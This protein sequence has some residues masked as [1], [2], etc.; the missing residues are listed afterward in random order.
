MF[1]LAYHKWVPHQRQLGPL[2]LLWDLDHLQAWTTHRR[3]GLRWSTIVLRR[4]KMTTPNLLSS[5]TPKWQRIDTGAARALG[6]R[7]RPPVVLQAHFSGD[8]DEEEGYGLAD[9]SYPV[10]KD[11]W[12]E[13]LG[14]ASGM[15]TSLDSSLLSG[16]ALLRRRVPLSQWL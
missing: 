1:Q 15:D 11:N 7:H 13:N 14:Y 9:I 2:D 4:C 8:E 12:Y 3:Q 16:L 5:R 10:P 6:V